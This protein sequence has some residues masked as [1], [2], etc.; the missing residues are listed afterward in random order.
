[1]AISA[2]PEDGEVQIGAVRLPRG[3]RVI[4]RGH[5]PV[6]AVLRSWEERFGARLLRIGPNA[7]VRLLVERP[8]RTLEQATLIANEHWAFADEF[9][10]EAPTGLSDVAPAIVGR[11]FWDFWWD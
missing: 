11:P 9:N 3:R 7:D 8:P 6:G 4:P 10:G 2:V 1:M 5:G